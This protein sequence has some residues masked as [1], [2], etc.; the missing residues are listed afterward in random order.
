[1]I[2]PL[3]VA[4]Q[5]LLTQATMTTLVGTRIAPQQRY[6]T[7]WDRANASLVLQWAGGPTD[8][9]LPIQ[10]QRVEV[11]A[12]APTLQEATAIWGAL[13]DISRATERVAVTVGAE[14][15]LL[16]AILQE[17]GPMAL[18]DT[19]AELPCMYGF[20]NIIVGETPL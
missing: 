2:E 7:D 19:D 10:T 14:Q 11:R 4:I 16:Y 20:Y 5:Y 13:V 8:L 1:M 6:G 12:L 18:R 17:G 3:S 15:G 9:Y